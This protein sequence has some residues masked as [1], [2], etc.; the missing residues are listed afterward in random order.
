[1]VQSGRVHSFRYLDDKIKIENNLFKLKYPRGYNTNE[2]MLLENKYFKSN[3]YLKFKQ[4]M[5]IHT[6]VYARILYVI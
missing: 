4:F 6:R 5:Y 3:V 2:E 1:M